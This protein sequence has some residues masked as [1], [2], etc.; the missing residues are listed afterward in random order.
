MDFMDI[1]NFTSG[2]LKPLEGVQ[3]KADFAWQ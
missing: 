2:T 3:S 1:R